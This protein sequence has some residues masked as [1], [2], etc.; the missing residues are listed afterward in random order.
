[1]MVHDRFPM[2]FLPV[3]YQEPRIQTSHPRTQ[4]KEF[5]SLAEY[6]IE[7]KC[8][9]QILIQ[10][11]QIFAK[12]KKKPW[13]PSGALACKNSIY[14]EVS[15]KLEVVCYMFSMNKALTHWTIKMQ[16]EQW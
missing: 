15:I 7:Q 2:D 14:Q 4:R 10:N 11:R 16:K 12:K 5:Y 8:I 3:H 1:M 9:S 13:A 6:R